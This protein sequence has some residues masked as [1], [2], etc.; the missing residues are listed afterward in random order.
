[1]F[2]ECGALKCTCPL[3]IKNWDYQQEKV[4]NPN[5]FYG[6]LSDC[7]PANESVTC[8]SHSPCILM[9]SAAAAEMSD[10]PEST[11]PSK[12]SNQSYVDK[13]GPI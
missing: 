6:R 12:L 7:S 10:Q 11:H 4:R 2:S 1:M 8:C 13:G 3:P 5:F 9:E